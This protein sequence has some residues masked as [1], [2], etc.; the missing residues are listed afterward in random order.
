MGCE[1]AVGLV[2]AEQ[3]SDLGDQLQHRGG[4][5]GVVDD[6]RGVVGRAEE[7]DGRPPGTEDPFHLV[8]VER[9]VR[10]RSP[11]TTS[12]PVTRLRCECSA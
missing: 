11:C 9:E 1:L 10:P 5:G 12:V 2:D 3:P 4:V 7:R 6:A 8:E